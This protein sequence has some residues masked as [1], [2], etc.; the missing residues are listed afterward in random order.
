MKARPPFKNILPQKRTSSYSTKLMT[1]K[2]KLNVDTTLREDRFD[3]IQVRCYYDMKDCAPSRFC[4]EPPKWDSSPRTSMH[5]LDL[6]AATSSSLSPPSPILPTFDGGIVVARKRVQFTTTDENQVY[7]VDYTT[8]A[9]KT[10]YNRNEYAKFKSDL[11]DTIIALYRSG[12]Q[13]H[14][15]DRDQYTV[16]GLERSLTHSQITE[17]KKLYTLYVQTMI[18]LQQQLQLEYGGNDPNQLGHISTMYTHSSVR[19]AQI[20]GMINHEIS[21][22]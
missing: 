3:A 19:R 12:G 7:Y 16:L 13:L 2:R 17:R 20:R 9:S 21:V 6:P 14:T 1:W 18:V 10:W 5:I 8:T 4:P 22:L 11:K 15:L